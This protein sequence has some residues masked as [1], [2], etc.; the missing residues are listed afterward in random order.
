MTF[1]PRGS[2]T[3]TIGKCLTIKCTNSSNHELKN[4]TI[5][6]TPKGLKW[7]LR[8]V[9]DGRVYFGIGKKNENLTKELEKKKSEFSSEFYQEQNDV[10][11]DY[12]KPYHRDEPHRIFSI[13]YD[14]TREVYKLVNCGKMDL[15]LKLTSPIVNDI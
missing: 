13:N 3:T 6:I 8:E 1:T 5:L 15:F 14:K 9:Q 10:I 11:L 2:I 4:K 7:G 12:C